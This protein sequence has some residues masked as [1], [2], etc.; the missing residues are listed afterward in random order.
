MSSNQSRVTAIA[1][2]SNRNPMPCAM[3]GPLK[4][5]WAS[6]VFNLATMEEALSKNAFKAMK[7]TVMT[8]AA[9]DPAVADVVAA[10]MKEWAMAKGAKFFS[11]IFYPMT[12]ITAEKHDSFIITSPEGGQIAERR[13]RAFQKALRDISAASLGQ[14][15]KI[16]HQIV[17]RGGAL[18]NLRHPLLGLRLATLARASLRIAANSAGLTALSAPPKPSRSFISSSASALRFSSARMSSRIYSLTL[19]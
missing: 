7:N 11:H 16:L 5:I 8:G 19:L 9:L 3:P 10:A 18:T 6:D 14:I 15:N 12:N 13:F 17:A 2:I 1:Q 4:D